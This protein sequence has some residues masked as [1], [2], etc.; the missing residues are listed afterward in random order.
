[1]QWIKQIRQEKVVSYWSSFKH[2]W[3]P[4]L[5][6]LIAREDIKEQ[7]SGGRVLEANFIEYS[8]T[9]LVA[10]ASTEKLIKKSWPCD[11]LDPWHHD[12]SGIDKKRIKR[13]CL[14][15]WLACHTSSSGRWGPRDQGPRIVADL[16][17]PRGYNNFFCCYSRF[18]LNIDQQYPR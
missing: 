4:A 7:C 15:D 8:K 12:F 2:G 1:M 16:I 5:K 9:A 11:I 13:I 18:I 3:S 6:H 17:S 10:C 14:Q